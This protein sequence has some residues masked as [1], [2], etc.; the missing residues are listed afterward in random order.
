MKKPVDNTFKKV[1]PI[2]FTG[3]VVWGV[4]AVFVLCIGVIFYTGHVNS[5]KKLRY[6]KIESM[7]NIL[8]ANMHYKADRA[9]G[10]ARV[11]YD[12]GCSL[13]SSQK[14]KCID[15]NMEKA[16]AG[17]DPSGYPLTEKDYSEFIERH[18]TK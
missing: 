4:I 18:R 1:L 8:I 9:R 3:K 7:T 11:L 2:I 17:V 6:Q 16:F 14:I 5:L 13:D 15:A 12:A 10:I